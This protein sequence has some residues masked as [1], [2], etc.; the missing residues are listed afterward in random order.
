V[1]SSGRSP[2]YR[3]WPLSYRLPIGKYPLSGTVS[4]MLGTVRAGTAK[5]EEEGLSRIDGNG[6]GPVYEEEKQE[7]AEWISYTNVTFPG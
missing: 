5:I 3:A 6:Q 2:F 7:A 1:T 4:E